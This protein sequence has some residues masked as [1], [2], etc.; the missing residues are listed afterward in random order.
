MEAAA[1]E[2]APTGAAGSSFTGPSFLPPRRAPLPRGRRQP[3]GIGGGGGGG[4][5][6]ESKG[7]RR[8][9][10][11]PLSGLHSPFGAAASVC[12]CVCVCEQAGECANNGTCTC[13]RP[14]TTSSSRARLTQHTRSAFPGQPVQLERLIMSGSG[15]PAAKWSAN[16]G[17]REPSL[18]AQ[19]APSLPPPSSA[20]LGRA[21]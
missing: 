9:R 4:G 3:G 7:F 6:G 15:S 13:R 20:E 17:S 12:V 19:Q 16:S 2:R 8:L 1:G 21:R 11:G 5:G 18:A 10:G 14:Q